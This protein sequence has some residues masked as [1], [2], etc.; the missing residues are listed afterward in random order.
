MP[1][2]PGPDVLALA[3]IHRSSCTATTAASTPPVVPL[4]RP[5]ILRPILGW[6][7]IPPTLRTTALYPRPESIGLAPTS[8]TGV[9]RSPK[10][11]VSN[12]WTPTETWSPPAVSCAIAAPPPIMKTPSL[13]SR[14]IS[15]AR[16]LH[17]A[18]LAEC[19][20]CR[21]RCL[22]WPRFV[23]SYLSHRLHYD[24]GYSPVY[25]HLDRAR[26]NHR[27]RSDSWVPPPLPPANDHYCLY[28]RVLS[29]QATPPVEGMGINTDV[30]NSNDLAW[31][32]I[33]IVAPGDTSRRAG[34]LTA[35]N[36]SEQARKSS[37]CGSKFR[38][39]CGDRPPLFV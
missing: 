26:N 20:L 23:G 11:L 27:H 5:P 30:A 9:R 24:P 13:A 12:L 19:C 32:N 17:T 37:R 36:I 31:R 4:R 22:L 18:Q 3:R 14:I 1:A 10:P 39:T 7:T 35:R 8:G 38:M 34:V 25:R 28:L 15:M 29:V 21:G 6:P 16:S 33:K 2:R